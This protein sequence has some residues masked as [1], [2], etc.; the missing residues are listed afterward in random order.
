MLQ[1][2]RDFFNLP[3]VSLLL[4][5]ANDPLSEL[6]FCHAHTLLLRLVRLIFQVNIA[7][8][9]NDVFQ[10][11]DCH[12]WF[13]HVFGLA[14]IDIC[15]AGRV[16]L[17]IANHGAF[18]LPFLL[19]LAEHAD[20]A[21][22]FLD[23]QASP[24]CRFKLVDRWQAKFE[25]DPRAA[26][27]VHLR[28]KAYLHI[29]VDFLVMRWIPCVAVVEQLVYLDLWVLAFFRKISRSVLTHQLRPSLGRRLDEADVA[30]LCS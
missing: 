28:R 4:K 8:V 15:Q 30:T 13:L 25:H 2:R 10:H 21:L 6:L 11:I 9:G 27:V 26:F 14:V 20:V 24:L 23:S 12:T 22:R 29:Q 17:C 7:W 16:E 19:F 18:E 5:H 3:L 1:V